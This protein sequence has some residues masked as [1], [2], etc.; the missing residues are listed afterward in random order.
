MGVEQTALQTIWQGDIAGGSLSHCATLSALG[1]FLMPPGN[2]YN[3]IA[4]IE[5]FIFIVSTSTAFKST[6]RILHSQL[7]PAVLSAFFYLYLG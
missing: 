3:L 7:F 1:S 5:S 4:V 2:H 6:N